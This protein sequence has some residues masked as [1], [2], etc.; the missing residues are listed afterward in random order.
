MWH[1]VKSSCP[2]HLHLI[3][4]WKYAAVPIVHDENVFP[5]GTFVWKSTDLLI[6]GLFWTFYVVHWSR[7]QSFHIFHTVLISVALEY[8][9]CDKIYLKYYFIFY[10]CTIH[11]GIKYIHNAVC[12]HYLC[13]NVFIIIIQTLC[14]KTVTSITSCQL[15]ETFILL[16]ISFY[17]LLSIAYPR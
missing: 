7:H 14:H 17:F 3:P 1:K 9:F 4:P 10:M 2:L 15:L 11:C 6:I 5:H 13:Q 16:Y 12:H 8:L